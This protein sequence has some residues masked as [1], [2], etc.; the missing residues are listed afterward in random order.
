MTRATSTDIPR[1]PAAGTGAATSSFGMFEGGQRQTPVG[2]PDFAAIQNSDEFKQIRRRL[3]LFA[4][5]MTAL[6]L[7]LYLAYVLLSAFA[8]D[9]MDQKFV[10]QFN[11]GMVLG[12]VQFPVTIIITHLYVRYMKKHVD[13]RV[14]AIRERVGVSAK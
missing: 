9:F 12:L 7:A 5:P 4:F 3:R 1:R 10:G 14:E 11:V 2:E 8:H 13:P 6:F